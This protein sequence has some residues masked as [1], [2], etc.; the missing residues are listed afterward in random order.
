MKDRL[1]TGLLWTVAVGSMAVGLLGAALPRGEEGDG[2]EHRAEAQRLAAVQRLAEGDPAEA[3]RAALDALALDPDDAEAWVLLGDLRSRQERWGEAEAAYERATELDGHR[4]RPWLQLGKV[5]R[6]VGRP[7][8][9]REAIGKARELDPDHP[10]AASEAAALAE[11]RGDLQHAA[12]L[13]AQGARRARGERRANLQA[14]LAT[15]HERRGD[16]E[17][18][19]VALRAAAAAAPR[20]PER[21]AALAAAWEKEGEGAEA[22]LALE[23]QAALEQA[24]ALWERAGDLHAVSGAAEKAFAA[25]AHAN[26]REDRPAAW[27]GI[28]RLRLAAGDAAGAGQAADRALAARPTDDRPAIAAA[29]G[30]LLVDLGRAADAARVLH[31]LVRRSGDPM[32]VDTLARAQASAGQE[33]KAL[34]TCRQLRLQAS[35]TAP[36][37][38]CQ[39]LLGRQTG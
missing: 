9:A 11:E 22:A 23:R 39:G 15:L 3:T 20:D 33:R 35:G 13:L 28:A 16:G 32:L 18:A 26:E 25:Y 19:V 34:G 10:E 5:Y 21:W 2:K 12:D 7:A 14:R 1:R 38:F 31:P 30:T 4:F 29:I 27:L 6:A 8:A 36:G 17:A 24:P 37:L